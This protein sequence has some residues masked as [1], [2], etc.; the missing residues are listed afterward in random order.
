MSKSAKGNRGYWEIAAIGGGGMVGG[1]IFAAVNGVNVMLAE[2]TRSRGWLS[3]L[4]VGLCLGAL[5]C[6]LWHTA[7]NSPG[8]LSVPFV[9]VGANL[10]IETIFRFTTRRRLNPERVRKSALANPAV[11][12]HPVK[13]ACL[14]T[15]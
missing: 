7:R 12:S 15:C 14:A 5:A 2:K 6:L 4:G 3:L 8:Q 10:L 11:K 9:M 1:G 13:V